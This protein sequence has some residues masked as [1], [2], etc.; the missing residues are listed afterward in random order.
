MGHS[1]AYPVFRTTDADAA[2]ARAKELSRGL[3]TVED[4]RWVDAVL[5]DPERLRRVA[6][7]LPGA[8]FDAGDKEE[9]DP[10]GAP[11]PARFP[12]WA[13]SEEAPED[14]VAPFLRAVGDA[15]AL[16][17]WRGRWPGPAGAVQ[18]DGVRVVFH[19]DDVELEPER[20]T[21]THTVFLHVDKGCPP[22]RVRELAALGGCEPLGGARIGW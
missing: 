6:E 20:P 12:V 14:A 17:G 4:G 8:S 1:R 7:A 18:Y 9:Y 11:E 21:R 2:Y 3:E 16:L 13:W 22:E 10:W 15:Q 5:T 19:G